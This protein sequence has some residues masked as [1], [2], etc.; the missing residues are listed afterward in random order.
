MFGEYCR[1]LLTQPQ[2]QIT[3]KVLTL[4]YKLAFT[5][6]YKFWEKLLVKTVLNKQVFLHLFCHWDDEVRQCTHMIIVFRTV[7]GCR[8]Q[9]PCVTDSYLI[10]RSEPVF[11]QYENRNK[12]YYDA[13]KEEAVGREIAEQIG[14]EFYK[15]MSS[16]SKPSS[17]YLQSATYITNVCE[18]YII[19]IVKTLKT[20]N[21]EYFSRKYYPYAYQS[22]AG[23]CSMLTEYYSGIEELR[24]AKPNCAPAL[25]YELIEEPK[26]IG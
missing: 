21:Y 26:D 22:I 4:F 1:L 14:D 25:D 16:C 7:T 10:K 8:S 2:Y 5:F 24:K 12:L 11:A 20:K 18:H 3:M 17:Q 19:N 9:L 6:P 13:T 23:Y 15:L